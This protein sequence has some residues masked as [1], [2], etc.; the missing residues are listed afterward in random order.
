M[1]EEEIAGLPIFRDLPTQAYKV[2]LEK[3]VSCGILTKKQDQSGTQYEAVPVD[4]LKNKYGLD[5]NFGFEEG[6][7]VPDKN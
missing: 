1:R 7:V 5:E 2:T 3:L 6:V 4:D